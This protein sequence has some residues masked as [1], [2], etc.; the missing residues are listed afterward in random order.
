MLN[1]E[2]ELFGKIALVTG[3]TKGVGKAIAERL[4]AAGLQ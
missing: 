4:M 1:F 3:G 2:N